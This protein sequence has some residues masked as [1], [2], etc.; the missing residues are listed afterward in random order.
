[1]ALIA[2]VQALTDRL[3]QSHD[4]RSQE[5]AARRQAVLNKLERLG[6]ERLAE[7]ASLHAALREDALSRRRAAIGALETLREGSI[8]RNRAVTGLLDQFSRN[9]AATA[10]AQHALLE[11]E[12]ARN[13]AQVSELLG[14]FH[15]ERSE[16]ARIWNNYIVKRAGAGSVKATVHH[17]PHGL[18][19]RIFTFLARHPNG[20]K[21]HDIERQFHASRAGIG[22]ALDQLI[23]Q[24]RARKD[25]FREI[26][27][28]T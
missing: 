13:R 10:K 20:V 21:I 26:F 27:F 24:N 11:T 9:L 17:A 23:E 19:E 2:D 6:S 7:E 25:E 14:T 3:A 18:Q 12:T 16:T 28:A 22:H 4:E 5:T 8:A 15:T 1:M